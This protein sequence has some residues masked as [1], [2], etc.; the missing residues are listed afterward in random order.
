MKRLFSLIVILLVL[1]WIPVTVSGQEYEYVIFKNNG[2]FIRGNVIGQDADSSLRIRTRDGK[3]FDVD[4]ADIAR[5]VRETAAPDSVAY[6]SSDFPRPRFNK[7]KGYFGLMQISEASVGAVFAAT[8]YA[9]TI[10]NG[11]RIMPQFAVGV[12]TGIAYCKGY[13]EFTVPVFI[14]LRSDFLDRKVS[15]YVAV[16]AGYNISFK[17]MASGI[18]LQPGAGVSFNV[19]SRYRMTAGM[20]IPVENYS[21]AVYYSLNNPEIKVV[22]LDHRLWSIGIAFNIGFSF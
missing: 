6:M 1:P 17:G 14:H 11:Y 22:E 13:K 9:L 4:F 10:V 18:S 21:K 3:V 16:N 15:P 2:S 12:G 5:I 7:P 19:G 8:R 20:D